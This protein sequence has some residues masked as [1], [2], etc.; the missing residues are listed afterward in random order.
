[1]RRPKIIGNN[2]PT[3]VKFKKEKIVKIGKDGKVDISYIPTKTKII[4]KQGGEQLKSRVLFPEEVLALFGVLE[5]MGKSAK[6]DLTNFKMC[7]LTGAR[8]EEARWIQKNPKCFDKEG[9]NVRIETQKVKVKEKVRYTRLSNAAMAEIGHFFNVDRFLPTMACWDKKLKRW[10]NLAGITDEGVSSRMMRKTY[11]SWLSFYFPM[12]R[13]EILESQ[14]HNEA[15][16]LKYY[17]KI[18]FIESD[19]IQMKEFV[20]GWI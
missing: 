11:E 12:R 20:E 4:G 15:T 7:L 14:G 13:Y 6:D 18:P 2:K 19:K 9:R 3:E 1:M 8:Y 5:K 17:I 10:A 16:A